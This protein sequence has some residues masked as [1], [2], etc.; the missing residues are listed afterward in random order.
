[1]K[2][3]AVESKLLV[4]FELLAEGDRLADGGP[5][6][7]GSFMNVPGAKREAIPSSFAR[8]CHDQCPFR[9][10]HAAS[11]RTLH[12]VRGR[13][14]FVAGEITGW[15]WQAQVCDVTASVLVHEP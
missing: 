14:P 8:L 15:V 1:M 4:D 6:R 9:T 3:H 7:V 11:A 10:A 5:E 2:L 13:A 12:A